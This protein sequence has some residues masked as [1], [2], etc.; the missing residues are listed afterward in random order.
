MDM[1]EDERALL[2]GIAQAPGDATPVRVYADWL[3]ER[4]N[5]P[6]RAEFI[7]HRIDLELG[8]VRGHRKGV[9]NRRL[10][11]LYR[12]HL[13]DLFPKYVV[14]SWIK[15][16]GSAEGS[17]SAEEKD[18]AVQQYCEDLKT[19]TNK[20]VLALLE[21]RFFT[22][23]PDGSNPMGWRYGLPHSGYLGGLYTSGIANHQEPTP[24]E[25]ENRLQKFK[26]KL[27]RARD[28][29]PSLTKFSLQNVEYQLAVLFVD[30]LLRSGPVTS[31]FLAC[32]YRGYAYR[33]STAH[34]EMAKYFV[35][36]APYV[37]NLYKYG[38]NAHAG[39]FSEMV[40]GVMTT[41]LFVP[42]RMKIR[43]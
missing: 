26:R 37:P 41:P 39:F 30:A 2:F 1:S 7:R 14:W 20:A 27:T 36:E 15:P 12:E 25:I 5:R 17:A 4:G 6:I 29:A 16:D 24:A 35:N 33:S 9:I 42:L 19:L 31:L 28:L 11:E 8:E 34:E 32:S 18:K 23:F 40:R 22:G 21:A 38:P 13:L 10:V 3:E 43:D